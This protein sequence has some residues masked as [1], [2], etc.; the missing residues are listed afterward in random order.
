MDWLRKHAG[1]LKLAG[2]ILLGLY[3]AACAFLYFD[4]QHL[5]YTP[6]ASTDQPRDYGLKGFER[7]TLTTSD[8]QTLI[9]WY[10]KAAPLHPT[11]LYLHG[12]LGN[13][14]EFANRYKIL[15]ANGDGVLAVDYRGFGASTGSPTEP[16]LIIDGETAYNALIARE[17][18]LSHIIIYGHSLGSG[19]A[20]AL[21]ARHRV[22]ALVLEAP[23]SSAVDVGAY[24]YPEFPVRD[25]MRD[26]FRSDLRI[27]KVKCP[28]LIMHGTDDKTVPY[29][30]GKRL[31]DLAPQPKDMF[32]FPGDGHDLLPAPGVAGKLEAWLSARVPLSVPDPTGTGSTLDPSQEE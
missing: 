6:V 28:I 30:F 10:K 1:Q 7:L 19:I 26:Q 13:L 2:K 15:S 25:L 27:G 24:R 8:N 12:N 29:Q 23:F 9:A 20:V 5:E 3:V 17:I 32:T 22:A 11:L 14:G 4:Q 21:A 18:G 31:F 16:G